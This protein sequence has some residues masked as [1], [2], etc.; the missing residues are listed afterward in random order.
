MLKFYLV[1]TNLRKYLNGTLLKD[2]VDN[3]YCYADT[4]TI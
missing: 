1:E 2:Q 4:N 3:K